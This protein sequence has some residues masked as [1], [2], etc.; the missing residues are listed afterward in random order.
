MKRTLTLSFR[1]KF[2]RPRSCPH[3]LVGENAPGDKS[4]LFHRAHPYFHQSDR[5]TGE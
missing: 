2:L 4:P 5:G 3:R 1:L